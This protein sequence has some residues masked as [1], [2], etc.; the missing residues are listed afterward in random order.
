MKNELLKQ[1]L[2]LAVTASAFKNKNLFDT[3]RLRSSLKEETTED[4]ERRERCAK[5]AIEKAQAKRERK[6][7]KLRINARKE[8]NK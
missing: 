2:I 3:G 6:A 8:E 7:S 1:A 5:L 4:E